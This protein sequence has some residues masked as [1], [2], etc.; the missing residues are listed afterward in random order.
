MNNKA[1]KTS[2]TCLF[3]LCLQKATTDVVFWIVENRSSKK[4]IMMQ[5]HNILYAKHLLRIMSSSI[6]TSRENEILS[7]AISLVNYIFFS[8]TTGKTQQ[9]F[10]SI[11]DSLQKSS[12]FQ[13]DPTSLK[14][15][16]RANL[17]ST[18]LVS[19][20]EIDGPLRGDMSYS[21]IRVKISFVRG[22][23]DKRSVL[24]LK[25]LVKEEGVVK[26]G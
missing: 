25:G 14:K 21:G 2:I 16:K 18:L 1:K 7:Q 6:L 12:F 4:A 24:K 3:C 11:A 15:L 9:R 26:F 20:L 10:F 8:A 22:K 5:E 17:S 13:P 23:S 19:R